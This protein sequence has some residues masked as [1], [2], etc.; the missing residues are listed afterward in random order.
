[1]GPRRDVLLAFLLLLALPCAA[2]GESVTVRRNVNLRPTPSTSRPE[3]RLLRP[4]AKLGLVEAEQRNGFLHV[5]ST[6][7]NEGWVWARNVRASEARP[8]RRV[9]REPATAVS[10]QRRTYHARAA[11]ARATAGSGKACADSLADC[12]A[13]G[14]AAPGSPDALVNIQKKSIPDT[15]NAPIQLSFADLRS[16]QKAADNA[17]M[18]GGSKL[19]QED[20]DQL[21]ALEPAGEGA[22]V[23]VTGYIA[24][25]RVIKWAGPESVN[26]KLSGW[27]S[28]DVHVPVVEQADQS[29]F[30]SLVVEPIPQGRSDDLT[31]DQL[32]QWQEKGTLLR[33]RGQL[34]CDNKHRVNDDPD[35]V[36]RSEPKRF[37]LFE[38]HPVLEILSCKRQDGDCRANRTSDWTTLRVR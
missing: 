11:T 23:E 12:P 24:P 15:T 28:N 8:T 3:I 36:M 31:I 13:E 1:M 33:I 38:V 10:R 7:G 16:L 20:R 34:F 22:Y 17:G 27:Q 2:F 35:K 30:E 6:D 14:C 25:E 5:R 26:C 4:G 32:A 29:E 9:A 21:A 19:S 18:G 37:T